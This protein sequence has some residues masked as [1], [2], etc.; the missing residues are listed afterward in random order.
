MDWFGGVLAN[1]ANGGRVIYHESHDEAGNSY[2]R[3][4]GQDV[5]SARTLVV[6][7]NG[8][9]LEGDTRRYAEARVHVAAGF[10]LLA[11]ATPMF[12]MGEEV[13]VQK[14]YRYADFGQ[15]RED[16]HALR[17]NAGARLFRFYQDLIRLRLDHPAFRSHNIEILYVHD[18]NRILA[19]R[20]WEMAEEFLVVASLNN[21][22]FGAGYSIQSLRLAGNPWREVFNSAAA[23]YG[24]N[25]LANP[26]PVS[27]Q[28]GVFMAVLPANSL[29]VFRH[30]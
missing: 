27:A 30:Q 11:P 24:G 3:E 18:A 28:G 9:A 1:A 26:G 12:F 15:A 2:Y 8:A 22:D 7:V 17:A 4:N 5:H 6:A 13:G 25:G 16:F 19:F 20:R 21:R 29:L 23:T 14:P 10:T